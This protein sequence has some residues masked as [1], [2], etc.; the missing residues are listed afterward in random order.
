M[1]TPIYDFAKRYAESDALRLHMPGHKG[2]SFTGTE[3]MDI[4]EISGADALF[5][6]NGIIAE[7]ERNLSVLFN[8][9]A[10]FYSTEGSS[11][12]IRAMLLM[13]MQ[14]A[15]KQ[16][17][18]AKIIAGRN[19]HRAF[20]TAASMLNFEYLWLE[21]DAQASYLSCKPDLNI[22]EGMLAS[23]KPI[24]VYLTCPDYLGN[25][26]DI[27]AV[28]K[29]CRKYDCLLLVDNAHGAYLKFLPKSRH[30]IDL[31]ADLSCDSAHKTLPA[32]TGGAYLHIG[33][34][35]PD[36]L[37]PLA[38]PAMAMFAST[39]P[40]YL[41]LESLDRANA[42]IADGFRKKLSGFLPKIARLKK[43]LSQQGFETV[44][45][46]PMKLTLAPKSYGYTGEEIAALLEEKGV[47]CEFSDRDF[48]VLMLSCEFSDGMLGRIEE[49]FADIPRRKP[50]CI[51]PPKIHLPQRK[52]HARDALFAPHEII[53]V[54][55][56]EGR[57]FASENI[58][59]PPAVPIVV[60]GEVIDSA[61]VEL[62]AYY[63]VDRCEV[64]HTNY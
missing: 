59:C 61:A 36:A 37:T 39:S 45:D 40:S 51:A 11:L 44:G 58:A 28:S 64:I 12:C 21:G 10:S 29:L 26:I 42:Y 6:A 35:A 60:S 47:I 3:S 38:K 5:Q 56:S 8:T 63:G 33:K 48:I 34:N 20:I 50:I 9:A 2:I 14:Y 22:L 13:A 53:S 49:A 23:E 54:S 15:K 16:G 17:R 52:M 19:A 30:P 32:L 62:F 1:N 4:T 24:A 43:K 25:T 31:G 41:I 7:S 55:E 18:Q 46:E 27:A 57:I